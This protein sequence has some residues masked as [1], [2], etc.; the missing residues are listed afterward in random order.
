MGTRH[1]RRRNKNV[2][3]ARYGG[4]MVKA[5][6]VYMCAECGNTFPKW[7][8]QCRVCGEWGTLQEFH[9]PSGKGSAFGSGS[10]LGG[11][12]GRAPAP[13]VPELPAQAITEVDVDSA[14]ASGSGIGELD[15][16]LGGG[17]VPGAVILLAG[18]PGIGKSTLLLEV[19]SRF[20]A[21]GEKPAL[22]ITGE[23]SV[24]QVRLRGERI[25]AS[26]SNLLLAGENDLARVLGQVQAVEPGLLILDSV[27]TISS[28]NVEGAAGG[29][30]QVRAVTSGIIQEAKTRNM[31]VLLVGHVTKSGGIAG[32]RVLEHLVDVV[33]YFEGERHSSLR[34]LRSVKNRYGPTDE[35]GC[36]QI[37]EA[38]ITELPDP[39]GLFLS[40]TA[41][42][43]PGTCVTVTLE[44]HR[45]MPTE[46]QAL[47]APGGPS[48]RRTTVGMDGARTAMILAVLQARMRVDLRSCDVYVSTVGGARTSEPA[49]DLAVAL[50]V[51]SAAWNRE[52][53]S[54]MVAFG[55][56][57]LTGEV[58]G[59]VGVQRRL[60][61]AARLGFQT[62]I[63][64]QKGSAELR[65]PE[66]MQVYPVTT[67]AEAAGISLP[68]RETAD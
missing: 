43:V 21:R 36:F 17:I 45:P 4:I 3:G 5:K 24:S 54:R 28:A 37:G 66:G 59:A 57:G 41:E 9:E 18:E 25:A 40:E 16:V 58:R 6:T 35:V 15:R 22:Y 34:M 39:S 55:E 20:A 31:P 33:C 56:V 63:V 42:P 46:I 29:V 38:G 7:A 50:A 8:G 52:P 23:E 13:I 47:V 60:Q 67:I 2:G 1:D 12:A 68:R 10:P 53:V 65:V 11:G 27:Q 48:P 14:D 49:V 32:P 51:L 64:P 26:E 62:A 19:A 30:S 61:E 44:G